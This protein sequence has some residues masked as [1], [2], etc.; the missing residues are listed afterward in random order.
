MAI[1]HMHVELLKVD[2]HFGESVRKRFPVHNAS[3]PTNK[4][5]QK[6]RTRGLHALAGGKLICY[7]QSKVVS[8]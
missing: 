4:T 2:K 8:D 7:E 1:S 6:M 5:K 3:K